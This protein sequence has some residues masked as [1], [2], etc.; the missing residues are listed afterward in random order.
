MF[1][2]PVSS[3][4]HS[5]GPTAPYMVILAGWA[6]NF[7]DGCDNLRDAHNLNQRLLLGVYGLWSGH[8]S[9]VLTHEDACCPVHA[10]AHQSQLGGLYRLTA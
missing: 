9:V 5:Q 7:K 8:S 3:W 2:D 10:R 4:L 1:G 6:T